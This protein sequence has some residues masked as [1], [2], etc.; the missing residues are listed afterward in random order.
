MPT[1]E[2]GESDAVL[3]PATGEL[4]L[5]GAGARVERLQAGMLAVVPAHERVSVEN[6]TEQPAS[7][8]VC[9]APATFVEA[10]GEAPAASADTE[11]AE[12]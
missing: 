9:F 10:L 11:P 8:L 7:M 5:R 1:H 3:I 4:L 12:G 6:P 2:H